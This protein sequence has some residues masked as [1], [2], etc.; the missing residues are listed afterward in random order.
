MTMMKVFID[1]MIT[2]RPTTCLMQATAVWLFGIIVWW[3]LWCWLID[4]DLWWL[5]PWNCCLKHASVVPVPIRN[6]L[7]GNWRKWKNWYRIQKLLGWYSEATNWKWPPTP[8][9]IREAIDGSDG[10]LPTTEYDDLKP[11]WLVSEGWRTTWR[12]HWPVDDCWWWRLWRLNRLMKWWCKWWWQE[13]FNCWNRNG[14]SA[15]LVLM[16][17]AKLTRY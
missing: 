8:T 13:K 12:Y 15:R 9:I 14:Y 16:M 17:S 6:I 4:D 5:W 3:N 7:V 1:A 10:K 2:A 11:A